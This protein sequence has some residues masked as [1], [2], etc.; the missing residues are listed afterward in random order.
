MPFCCSPDGS[1]WS[2]IPQLVTHPP[3]AYHIGAYHIGA[4]HIGE[5]Y[6][7]MVIKMLN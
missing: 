6:H 3:S 2:H 4:C 1:V 7:P 5:R